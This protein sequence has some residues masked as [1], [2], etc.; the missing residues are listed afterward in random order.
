VNGEVRQDGRT[1]ELVFPV[2]VVVSYIS[3]F[4]TLNPGDLLH[5]NARNDE[6]DAAREL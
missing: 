2:D 4:A 6:S 3:Q 5:R 1:S